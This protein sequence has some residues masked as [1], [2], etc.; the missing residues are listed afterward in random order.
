MVASVGGD[1]VL[2]G[3]T[4]STIA[5]SGDGCRCWGDKGLVA[6]RQ[7]PTIIFIYCSGNGRGLVMTMHVYCAYPVHY[8]FT[9]ICTYRL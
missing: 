7:L 5:K 8:V 9:S 6:K 3:E 1:K 2:F 4:Y